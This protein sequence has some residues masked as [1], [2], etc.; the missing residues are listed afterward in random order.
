MKRRRDRPSEKARVRREAPAAPENVPPPPIDD[1]TVAA[2]ANVLAFSCDRRPAPC[3]V[4]LSGRPPLHV[5]VNDERMLALLIAAA[6]AGKRVHI[7]Y[8]RGRTPAKGKPRIDVLHA[9]GLIV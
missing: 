7:E 9:V 1:P 6:T 2:D 4:K 3:V 5:A 8:K